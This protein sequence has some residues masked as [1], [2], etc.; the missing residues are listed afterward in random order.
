MFQ[1]RVNW[2]EILINYILSCIILL[3]IYFNKFLNYINKLT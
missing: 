2:N 3:L 1:T